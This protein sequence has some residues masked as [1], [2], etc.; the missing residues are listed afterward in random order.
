MP[1]PLKLF[2]LVLAGFA[3]PAFAAGVLG[4]AQDNTSP[5]LAAKLNK[6]VPASLI[7][8]L[9][10]ASKAGLRLSVVP[11][12][13]DLKAIDG[14]RL[15]TGDKVGLLYMGADFCPYCA[16]QR[17][18]LIL[19]L[20]RFGKLEGV[21]YMLSS[22]QDAY[23]NTPTFSFLHATYT[24]DHL[25]FQP[26]ETE[27]RN[28]KVLMKPTDEQNKIYSTYDAPPYTPVFGS[29][30]FIY[31]DGQYVLNRPMLLPG[32]LTGKDWDTAAKAFA[33]PQSALFQQAMPQ[34][35]ALTAAICRLD[36]GNPDDVCS[37]PGVTA[38]N[39]ALLKLSQGGS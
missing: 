39:G 28:G 6:P 33:D 34:V 7:T 8:T 19:T 4:S 25:V 36:G 22:S 29:I 27:D 24:S 16:G 20:V 31:L 30:P 26:V 38:A 32:D 3:S 5:A 23:P 10:Q 15:G 35:N 13:V 17:W 14:P 1:R 21:D 18:A 12:P 9:E 11:E 37:A 2:A